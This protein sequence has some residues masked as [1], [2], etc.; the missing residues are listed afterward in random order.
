MAFLGESADLFLTLSYGAVLALTFLLMFSNSSIMMPPSE[1]I[2]VAIGVYAASYRF[3]P[4]PFVFL[5]S[6][7]NLLGSSF[8]FFLGRAHKSR[9]ESGRVS[10]SERIL[11][12][13]SG[14]GSEYFIARFSDKGVLYVMLLRLFPVVRSIVS[15]PAGRS[16]MSASA[17]WLASFVGIFFW[18][19][20]L[21]G[22][23]FVF[24]KLANPTYVFSL[25][26]AIA[27]VVWLVSVCLTQ[28][29]RP[30]L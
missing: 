9:L 19:S 8:W 18:C 4:I 7:A 23:G 1:A 13:L 20:L 27:F 25:S 16:A 26:M 12:L 6:I 3:S 11:Q 21:I 30:S 15:Y 10:R 28:R 22:S 2:C 29:R 14:R 24:G 17:F 5:A